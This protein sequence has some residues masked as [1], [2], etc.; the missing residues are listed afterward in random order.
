MK[1]RAA[2][3]EPGCPATNSDPGCRNNTPKS[4][5]FK[6]A[7]GDILT[8]SHQLAARGVDRCVR[9]MTT[10][11]S[12]SAGPLRVSS[13]SQRPSVNHSAFWSRTQ[14]CSRD[15]PWVKNPVRP[16]W[17]YAPG[18]EFSSRKTAGLWPTDAWGGMEPLARI[19]LATRGLGNR[20]SI[21]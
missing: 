15:R 11:C 12:L 14:P 19:E 1:I 17:A 2:R 16:P 9:A 7:P 6:C 18:T 8:K 10:S 4:T 5:S 13:F 21:L 20:C 3:S